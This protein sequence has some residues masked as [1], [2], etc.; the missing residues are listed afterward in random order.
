MEKVKIDEDSINEGLK[1]NEECSLLSPLYALHLELSAEEYSHAQSHNP[2]C[3][4]TDADVNLYK[5]WF[6][7]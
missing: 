3:E 6:D 7:S 5:L 4:I 2:F 1:E